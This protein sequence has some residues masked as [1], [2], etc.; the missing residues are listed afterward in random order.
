M[1]DKSVTLL[2]PKGI[3]FVWIFVMFVNVYCISFK[4]FSVKN[5]K[6]ILKYFSVKVNTPMFC[7]A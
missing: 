7:A 2:L 6:L 5:L 1:R 4:C 3:F